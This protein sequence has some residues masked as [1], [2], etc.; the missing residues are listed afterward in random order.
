MT[1]IKQI[2][3]ACPVNREYS[4]KKTQIKKQKTTNF[5]LKHL[6]TDFRCMMGEKC[7]NI[8]LLVYIHR[9]IFLEYDKIINIYASNYPRRMLLINPPN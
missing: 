3:Q 8:L 4:Q 7:L 5:T 1:I 2:K 6:R 9:D